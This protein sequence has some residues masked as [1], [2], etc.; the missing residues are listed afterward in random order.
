M[1]NAKCLSYRRDF[2]NHA[3][4]LKKRLQAVQRVFNIRP[5]AARQPETAVGLGG[6][7]A[8]RKRGVPGLTGGWFGCGG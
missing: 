1:Y 6:W 2:S 8:K 7:K 3:M 4:R 5:L